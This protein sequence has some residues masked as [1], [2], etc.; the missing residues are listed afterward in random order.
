MGQPERH[1]DVQRPDR[2]RDYLL[3]APGVSA[4]HN[5]ISTQVFWDSSFC[6]FREGCDRCRG[7][8]R[9]AATTTPAPSRCRTV[10]E[11]DA[12]VLG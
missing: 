3:A 1:F 5:R 8:A 2:A 9:R 12:P 7:S 4:H 6:W 11:I 10:V